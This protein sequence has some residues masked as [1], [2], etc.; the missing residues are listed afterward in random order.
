MDC[1]IEDTVL[2]TLPLDVI[3]AGSEEALRA[4]VARERIV[5]GRRDIATGDETETLHLLI[6]G[7]AARYR[8]LDNGR[9]QITALILPGDLCDLKDPQSTGGT[10]TVGAITASTIGEIPHSALF[11]AG[12]LRPEWAD[13]AFRTIAR[14][15]DIASE[16]IVSLGQ[17]SAYEATAHL[18]CELWERLSAIGIADAAGFPCDLTQVDL[19]DTLG[20]TPVHVNR[21]LRDLRKDGLVSVRARRATILDHAGLIRAAD[22]DPSYLQSAA[23]VRA[24]TNPR[25]SPVPRAFKATLGR[26]PA[27]PNLSEPSV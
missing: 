4:C 1:G 5:A 22:F 18:F 24:R 11:E 16:W 19:A 14:E 17:R 13:F 9:R 25:I 6:A 15:M 10:E 3:G 7:T 2:T 26:I 21:T 27:E 8:M 12:R 20:L 23:P